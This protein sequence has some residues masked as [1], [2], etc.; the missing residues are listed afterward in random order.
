MVLNN[1]D[2]KH[3]GIE[4]LIKKGKEEWLLIQKILNKSKV[5]IIGNKLR[6]SL[7]KP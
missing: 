7:V 4:H 5:K 2:T 3:D 1:F 6:A